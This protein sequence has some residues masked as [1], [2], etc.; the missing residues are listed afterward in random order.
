MNFIKTTLT[1]KGFWMTVLT[2]ILILE[3]YPRAKA[4]LMALLGK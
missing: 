4:K 2:T 3:V 1:S